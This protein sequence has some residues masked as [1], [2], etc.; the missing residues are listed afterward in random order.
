MSCPLFAA[1]N[2]AAL[3]FIISATGSTF[4]FFWISYTSIRA[5]V[6]KDELLGANRLASLWA[7]NSSLVKCST[8]SWVIAP[9]LTSALLICF[10]FAAM[11]FWLQDI[12]LLLLDEVCVSMSLSLSSREDAMSDSGS[13]VLPAQLR[14]DM[15]HGFEIVWDRGA[16]AES[17]K[18]SVK[19]SLWTDFWART[20]QK[21]QL[22]CMIWSKQ[23]TQ[24][25]TCIAHPTPNPVYS[26]LLSLSSMMPQY[27]CV[28]LLRF[29]NRNSLGAAPRSLPM[30]PPLQKHM[31]VR[32]VSTKLRPRYFCL[33]TSRFSHTPLLR[34]LEQMFLE[35]TNVQECSRHNLHHSFLLIPSPV[36]AKHMWTIIQHCHKFTMK[37]G[38]VK[39]YILEQQ[40]SRRN[41][42][43]SNVPQP[44]QHIPPRNSL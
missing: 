18:T 17:Q 16:Q 8:C 21:I 15:I 22:S 33:R 41:V 25:I 28:A 35:V 30:L 38:H 40:R 14:L 32:D 31:A 11:V 9:W 2:C 13:L 42:F 23:A 26:T 10:A 1:M 24:D 36:L 3:K 12:D 39:R 7:M 43:W 27:P 34:D 29:N 44:A 37:N 5:S 6:R 19:D 20:W 4:M